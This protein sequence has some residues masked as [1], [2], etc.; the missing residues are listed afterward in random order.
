MKAHPRVGGENRDQTRKHSRL[1]GSSPRGRGKQDR[2]RLGHHA[3]RLIPAW[4]GKTMST[5]ESYYP[6]GA[7]PRVGGENGLSSTGR[8]AWYGSSPRGRGK[9]C[10]TGTSVVCAGLIPAW[11]GKTLSPLSVLLRAPAHPRVG[12]ENQLPHLSLSSSRGSSPRGRGKPSDVLP[13]LGRAGLIPAWAGK[14]M[15]MYRR[16]I[17][18][19][20]HPRVGGENL[21]P[22]SCVRARNGSSPR[23]RGKRP[24]PD[25][26]H[27]DNGLIPAWAGKTSAILPT[28]CYS[29]AHPRVGGENSH[30]IKKHDTERGSSPRGRGKHN[31][32]PACYYARGLIPAWA[33]KTGGTWEVTFRCRA[34]P[35]VGGENQTHP[36]T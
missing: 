5:W 8:S 12:G 9:P 29:L 10:N 33:G 15:S 6:T 20:A 23:G 27:L 11:A 35:R 30:K 21:R 4:A 32:K 2:V 36:G 25:H 13:G 14:T 16:V 7:H 19:P 26:R 3:F 28:Y 17:S 34:H 18:G 22:R 31:L 24:N 1:L